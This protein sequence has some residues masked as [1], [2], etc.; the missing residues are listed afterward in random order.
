VQVAQGD[1]KAAL[2]SYSDSLAI[3]ERLANSDPGNAGWQ[4]DLAVAWGMVGIVQEA[5]GNLP[6][7]LKS[8]QD[9]LVVFQ[10]LAKPAGSAIS[11]SNGVATDEAMVFGSAP[12]NKA[13]T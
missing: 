11:R 6:G 12:G 10:R 2:K 13:I 4:R 7:A 5:Q 3:K 1:L 8:Y 9:G